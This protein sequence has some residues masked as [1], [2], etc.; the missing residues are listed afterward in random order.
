MRKLQDNFQ[1]Y[2]DK[3]VDQDV[4]TSFTS[5]ANK[6]KKFAKPEVKV[7]REGGREGG[8]KREGGGEVDREHWGREKE[9]E[10]ERGR[11]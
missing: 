10:R 9:V 4:Y 3:L 8:R 5:I 11:E 2:Q 6:A 7:G 1:C